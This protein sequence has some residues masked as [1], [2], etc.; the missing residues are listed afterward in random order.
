VDL[1]KR[2][3]G[4]DVRTEFLSCRV[5]IGVAPFRTTFEGRGMSAVG[6]EREDVCPSQDV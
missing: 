4:E 5:A 2:L 1:R 3:V 6:V